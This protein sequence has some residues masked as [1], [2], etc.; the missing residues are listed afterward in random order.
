[1]S[2]SRDQI[3]EHF[4]EKFRNELDDF[5]V[6]NPGLM[7]ESTTPLNLNGSG[8][9]RRVVVDDRP[10]FYEGRTNGNN[11]HSSYASTTTHSPRD[12]PGY[13]DEAPLPVN[14]PAPGRGL[15]QP[16]SANWKASINHLMDT[17][18]AS[19]DRAS[20]LQEDKARLEEKFDAME[21]D[22]SNLRQDRDDLERKL[23]GVTGH[24]EEL[25]KTVQQIRDEK[26]ASQEMR[27]AMLDEK[28]QLESENDDLRKL[29][30]DARSERDD[31]IQQNE[32]LRHRIREYEQQSGNRTF[33]SPA[34]PVTSSTGTD[35]ERSRYRTAPTSR[36]TAASTST[37]SYSMEDTRRT[38]SS[39]SSRRRYD[40]DARVTPSS[41]SLRSTG[42]SPGESLVR[43]LSEKTNLNPD[44]LAPLSDLLDRRLERNEFTRSGVGGTTSSN[45]SSRRGYSG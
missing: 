21:Q 35:Y 28:S 18:E 45:F 2:Y 27:E 4:V 8:R 24:N 6:R 9:R 42:R 1:M 3:E 13:I 29:L 14:T 40:T 25:Q 32:R 33:S 43:E 12:D 30:R 10:Q 20:Q 17:I 23:R 31:V 36:S 38:P 34:N 44:D 26:L 15:R 7:K 11:T 39:A 37:H 16:T 5:F 19:S 41:T 22:F